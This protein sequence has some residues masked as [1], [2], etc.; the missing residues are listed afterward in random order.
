MGSKTKNP[1]HHLRKKRG[2]YYI[3]VRID[4]KQR[5]FSLHTESVTAARAKLLA[6]TPAEG[7]GADS[8]QAA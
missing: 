6:R 7:F 4:G 2:R 8:A 5:E 1:D 3:A